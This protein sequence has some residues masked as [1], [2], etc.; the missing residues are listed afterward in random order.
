MFEQLSQLVQHFG[1]QEVVDN[2][3]VF[4]T[5]NNQF[6]GRRSAVFHEQIHREGLADKAVVGR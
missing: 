5:S 3:A 2:P 1:Q 6:F 4:Q